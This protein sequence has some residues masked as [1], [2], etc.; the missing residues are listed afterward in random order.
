[1]LPK[2]R[3]NDVYQVNNKALFDMALKETTTWCGEPK[4]IVMLPKGRHGE[5]L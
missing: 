4:K 1:M 5:H 3:H 2:G